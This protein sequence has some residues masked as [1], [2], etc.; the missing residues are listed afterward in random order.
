[1]YL[2]EVG[3]TEKKTHSSSIEDDEADKVRARLRAASQAQASGR[4]SRPSRADADEFKT[5]IDLSQ[6]SKPGDV[7][8]AIISKQQGRCGAQ[9]RRPSKPGLHRPRRRQRLPA[10][11]AKAPAPAPPAAPPRLVV[12]TSSPRP[13]FTR[14]GSTGCATNRCV[15]SCRRLQR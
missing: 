5:K 8:K 2:P 1:M 13:T 9:H 12:P 4:S 15:A 7:L 3:V 14:S 10:P 11:V 6:I